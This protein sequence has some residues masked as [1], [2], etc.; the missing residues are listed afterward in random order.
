M[1]DE[2]KFDMSSTLGDIAKA[3]TEAVAVIAA[4]NRQLAPLPGEIDSPEQYAAALEELKATKKLAKAVDDRRKAFTDPLRIAQETIKKSFDAETAV[5]TKRRDDVQA[6]ITKWV[7]KEEERRQRQQQQELEAAEAA[8]K[9]L[10]R[11]A[12]KAEGKGQEEKAADLL[13]RAE[14]T[15]APIVESTIPKVSGVGVKGVTYTFVVRHPEKVPREYCSPDPSLI[16]PRVNAL[17]LAADIPGVL[18]QESRKI[19]TKG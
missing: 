16:R 13:D 19:T 5:L 12:E 10:L 7:D 4:N 6:A 18:V 14:R 3:A 11:E 15:V 1:A 2:V 9:K 8:R 17:G